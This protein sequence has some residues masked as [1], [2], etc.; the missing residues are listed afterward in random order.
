[1]AVFAIWDLE[2]VTFSGSPFAS[3]ATADSDDIGTTFV[4]NPSSTRLYAD[5][6]DNDPT[7]QD[8]DGTQELTSGLVVNSSS[9]TVGETIETE[10]S[11]VVR[12]VG[13][14]TDGS[15]D[16]TI[17]GIEISGDMVGFS[18]DGFLAPGIT[19]EIVAVD[20][21]D[22]EV[23]YSNLF[24]CF[25]Q[26]AEIQTPTGLRPVEELRINDFITTKDDGDLPIL[27]AKTIHVCGTG[28]SAPIRFGH[29]ALKALGGQVGGR[30]ASLTVSPQ[31]RMLTTTPLGDE[32]LVPA[33]AFVGW[34]DVAQT[35]QSVVAYTHILLEKHAL[36]QGG[37]VYSESLNPG[38]MTFKVSSLKTRMELLRLCPNAVDGRAYDDIRPTIG[39]GKW[40]RRHL[41][42]RMSA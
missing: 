18:A 6:V 8:G 11:Y 36:I 29:D 35:P 19:Y 24:I 10:Y 31:H 2:D 17:Y 12:A 27:W 38:P 7:F 9:Y 40:R 39:A 3:A 23:P 28:K 15:E 33:R 25:G 14:P 4:I 26:G 22:P 30:S 41:K 32:V 42:R 20:S 5:M 34:R 13:G 16:V 1:M 37:G 21:N